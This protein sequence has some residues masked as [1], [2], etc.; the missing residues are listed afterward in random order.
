MDPA[1][2]APATGSHRLPRTRGD[3]PS[4]AHILTS[5]RISG[6]HP[7]GPTALTCWLPE[8]LPPAWAAIDRSGKKARNQG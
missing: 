4:Q 5:K 1:D 6:P 8:S 2:G 3:A 7:R